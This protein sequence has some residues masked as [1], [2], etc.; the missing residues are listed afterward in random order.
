[1]MPEEVKKFDVSNPSQSAAQPALPNGEPSEY[2]TRKLYIDRMLRDDGWI[3]G[4]NWLN[5]YELPG[6]PNKSEV[7]FA[8]YVLLGDDGRILAVI[9]AKRTCIDVSQGRQQAKLYADLIEEKQ[10]I[11]PVVFLSNGFET[12]IVDNQYPERKV[13]RIYSK[14]DL[15]KLVFFT[16]SWIYQKWG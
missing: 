9:E 4:K 15:E 7:G 5:E 8:D 1:M 16:N 10:G 12:R 2:K 13:A 6:M 11:R 14:R 3:E